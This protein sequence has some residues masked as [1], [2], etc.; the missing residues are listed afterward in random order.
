VYINKT[1]WYAGCIPDSYPY[2]ITNTKCR[3]NT[4]VSPD[5]GQ[6]VARNM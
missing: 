2:R 5:D 4:A 1:L 6:T 3:I